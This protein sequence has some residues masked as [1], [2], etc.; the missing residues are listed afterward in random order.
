MACLLL[1][2][3]PNN[4]LLSPDDEQRVGAMTLRRNRKLQFVENASFDPSIT[5]YDASYENS[6]A[7]STQFSQ[8]MDDVL[9]LLIDRYPAGSRL[10]EVGCGKGDFLDKANDTG[11][12]V[13][14]GFDTTYTGNAPYIEKRYLKE[15]DR[16]EADIVVLRH[17]LEHIPQPHTFISMLAKIFGEAEIYVEVP[18]LDWIL[19]NNTFFDITYEH[20]NYFSQYALS[21]LFGRKVKMANLCFSDQYQ[22][23]IANLAEATTQFTSAYDGENWDDVSFDD[24]FPA[25]TKQIVN[26]EGMTQ[27]TGKCYFWGAA[28][29]GCMFLWHANR[30][31]RLV[32]VVPYAVDI[33]PDKQGRWL[34]GSKTAIRA[35]EDFYKDA[36]PGDLLV[37]SNPAY[38]QEIKSELSRRDL[39][40]VSVTCI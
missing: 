18:N 40:F 11:H 1:P 36:K 7:H 37:I 17:V 6:Q 9:K 21:A 22:F 16:I 30:L 3:T 39:D 33:N 12:F 13:C 31:N 23:V 4:P 28:T 27:H 32:D 2:T 14:R 5:Y 10:V 8:H 19:E 35:P 38:Q 15:D 34:P 24:L 25:L 20:V 26:L 29:K